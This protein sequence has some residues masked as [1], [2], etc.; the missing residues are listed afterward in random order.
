MTLDWESVVTSSNTGIFG[1]WKEKSSVISL[2]L[3]IKSKKN[4]LSSVAYCNIPTIANGHV[5]WTDHH[6]DDE[7]CRHKSY[8]LGFGEIY[9][10]C[11]TGYHLSGH[12]RIICAGYNEFRT[13]IPTCQGNIWIEFLF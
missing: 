6:C 4:K 10:T 11:D 13:S 2:I 12:G 7:T 5:A 3:N 1:L 9:I 8:S